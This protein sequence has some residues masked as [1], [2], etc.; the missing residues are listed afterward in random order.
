MNSQEILLALQKGKISLEEAKDELIKLKKKDDNSERDIITASSMEL[1]VGNMIMC[2]VW[3]SLEIRN[4]TVFPLK[5]ERV[6]I[7][8]GT[9]EN[10]ASLLEY[11]PGARF[12]KIKKGESIDIISEKVDKNGEI[13]H[14]IWIL[15]KKKT[16]NI[17]NDALIDAQEEGLILLFRTIKALLKLGYGVKNLC[18]SVIIDQTQSLWKDD[19]SNPAHA[20]V[21]GLMGSTANEYSTWKVRVIDLESGCKWPVDTLFG[22][23]NNV[24]CEFLAYRGGV[25]YKEKLIPVNYPAQI[26]SKYREGGVYVV[27]G[28]SGGIGEVWSEYMIRSYHAKIIW[29]GRRTIDE[30]IQKKLDRLGEIGEA[31]LYIAADAKNRNALEG[32]YKEIKEKYNEI[33]GVVHSAIVLQDRSLAM[34]EEDSFRACLSAKVD[35]S[36]RLAQVYKKEKL[37]FVLFFSSMQSFLKSAGQGNYASGSTFEDAFAEKLSH[38]W[39][40]CI[41]VINWGYWGSVGVVA[42]EDYR[43]R[44]E[45]YGAGSIEPPEAM[46]AL[47][48]LLSGPFDQI[49][50]FK[51]LKPLIIKNVDADEMIGINPE[52]PFIDTEKIKRHI[53]LREPLLEPLRKEIS[54]V[55]MKM[56]NLLCK[57]L[58]IEM[59]KMG[60]FSEKA[61]DTSSLLIDKYKAWINESIGILKRNGYLNDDKMDTVKGIDLI[62]GEEVWKEWKSLKEELGENPEVKTR[63]ILAEAAL[64]SLS[65]IIRGK[66]QAA[67]L[68]FPDLSVELVEDI[69]KYNKVRDYFNEVIADA[70]IGY[71]EQ[72]IQLD[73]S[74]L[75]RIL[76]VGARFGDTSAAVFRK[77]KDFKRHIK[78][79]CYTD[80]SGAFLK[81]GGIEFGIDHPYITFKML[82]VEEPVKQQGIDG[83]KYDIVIAANILHR[84]KDISMVLRNIKTL[85]K[86][87]GIA[88]F[89]EIAGKSVFMHLTFGLLESFGGNQEKCIQNSSNPGFNTDILKKAIEREGF[90]SL[91]F[92][93]EQGIDFGRIIMIARSD[94][95]IRYKKE[96]KATRNIKL[97]AISRI[98]SRSFNQK[99][100]SNQTANI[101]D[102]GLREKSIGFIKNLIADTLKMPSGRI[103]VLEP[104]EKYGIDSILVVRLNNS[105][106]KV[107]GENISSTLFYEYQT[108]SALVN[109]FL[110]TRKN[111]MIKLTGH[112]EKKSVK[113]EALMPSVISFRRSISVLKRYE[114]EPV[115]KEHKH[116]M[117]QDIAII[118]LSGRYACAKNVRE[119]WNNLKEG[120]NCIT[121]I[122][123]ERWD[124]KAY[125][126]EK[127]KPGKIYTKWGGFIEDFDKFDPLFFKISPREAEGMDPQERLFMEEAYSCIEDAGHTPETICDNKKVGVYVGVMNGNYPTGASYWSIANRLSYLFDFQGPSMAVDT[128]CSSSLTA[129]HLAVEG[130]HGGLCD[131]AIAG[132]VS[133]IVTP[134]HYIRLSSMT[135]LTPGERCKAF[136]DQADGFVDG[137]GVGA[138]LL[139]PLAKA[140]AD[141][142]HI[143]GVIK[144]SML[145]SG[146]KTNGYTVPNPVVQGE[147]IKEAIDKAGVNA[148]SISYIEAHGT[149]TVL[150]DPI[151]IAGLTRAFRL[152]TE[153]KQF[154]AI[155]SVKSNIGHCE[156]AAGI[157]SVT[158]VLLQLKHRKLVPS[159]HTTEL[160]PNINFCETPFVVQNKLSEW[161]SDTPRITGISSFGAGGANAHLVI[162]EYIDERL[163]DPT[164]VNA[165]YPAVIV[166]SAKDI[167]SLRGRAKSL[168]EA[169]DSDGYGNDS[170]ADIAYTLQIGREDM[171]ERL[172]F[173]SS[174][175]EEL[176]KKL[177]GFLDG[178]NGIVGIYQGQVKKNKEA[179]SLFTVDEDFQ[180]AIDNWISKGK[181]E[182]MIDLWVKGLNFNWKRLYADKKPIRISLPTYPFAK[183]RYWVEND[184]RKLF[185]KTTCVKVIHPLL[186]ENN[187]DLMEQRFSTVFSGEEFFLN[188]HRINGK[189]ILPGAVYLEMARAAVATATGNLNNGNKSILLK[190]VVWQTPVV[191]ENDPV[192]VNIGLIPGAN[193]EILFEVYSEDEVVHSQGIVEFVDKIEKVEIDLQTMFDRKWSRE[194]TAE[195]CY[196]AFI[197]AGVDYGQGHRG[198]ERIY[199]GDTEAIA[200]LSLPVSVKVGQEDY[201]LH[202][203]LM[204]AAFQA[205]FGLMD[206]NSGSAVVPYLI[207]RLEIMGDCSQSMWALV[208]LNQ[209]KDIKK[210]DID[211]CGES[212]EVCI[213][214]KGLTVRE[215]HKEDS[216]GILMLEPVWEEEKITEGIVGE[217]YTE[218]LVFLCELDDITAADV[219]PYLKAVKCIELKFKNKGNGIED[220]YQDYTI[221]MIEELRSII[222]RKPDG[223]VLIQ[224]LGS[225][226]GEAQLNRGLLGIL[227]SANLENPKIIGHLIVLEGKEGSKTIL[228]ILEENSLNNRIYI[229]KYSEGKRLVEKWKEVKK[230]INKPDIPW[231]NG[232]VYLITGGMGGLGR[233]FALDIAEKVNKATLILTGRSDLNQEMKLWIKG[234]EEKGA[235]V[236]Y[237]K[238]DIAVKADVELL[239]QGLE[240]KYGKL[241]GI[242]HSAGMIKDNY[243][244]K[245]NREEVKEVLDPKVNGLIY[246]DEASRKI[247]LDIFILFSSITGVMGN[248]GQADYAAANGFMDAFAHYR[249]EDVKLKKR[250]GMTIS[251]DWPMWK[252]GGMKIDIETEKMLYQQTG[253]SAMETENGIQALYKGLSLDLNQAMVIEGDMVKIRKKLLLND[254]LDKKKIVQHRAVSDSI[255]KN[256][257]KF[258]LEKIQTVLRKKVSGLLK[259]KIE[260]IDVDSELNEYGFDSITLTAFANELNDKFK[261]ELTPAIFFEHANLKSL[262]EYMLKEHRRA[263]DQEKAEERKDE[264]VE[265][266]AETP[267]KRES[268]HPR[269]IRG[270]QTANTEKEPIAIVGMSG[271]FPEAKDIE[272]FWKNLVEEKD[273]IREIPEK[274]WDWRKYYGDP[275]RENNKTNIKWGGFIE[276]VDE[277]DPLFFGISPREAEL[278]DPQQRLLMEYVWKAIED[279]GY[280]ADTLSGSKSGIFVGTASNGYSELIFKTKRGIEGY[281][282]TGIV[283]SVGPNRMSYFLNLHGPSE[284]VETACS[285]SLVAIHRAVSAIH[286]GSCEM[287]IAGGI[288]TIISPEIHISFYKAGML[289]EDGRCKTFSDKA[290]GYVRGEGVGMLFL[291]KLRTAEEDG[292]HIYGIIRSTVENHGGRANSLTAP[293]PKAQAELLVSAYVKA[294]IDPRTVTYV[295]A[296]GT[297]TPLGDPIEING[298]KMAFETLF[299]TVGNG[300]AANHYCG[301]GTVKSNIGHLELAAGVA[302]VIKV[303]LQL[304]YK[305]L[306]KS[307]HCE[308]INPYIE[309][310]GS[311]F[312]ILQEKKEWAPLKD[313][314]GYDIPRRAG[315]S[316]FGFGGVNAHVVIEEYI[317]KEVYKQAITSFDNPSLIVLSAKNEERLKE[318]AKN[319]LETIEKEAFGDEK[320]MEIA[321]TLQVGREEM[322]ERLGFT[323]GTIVELKEKL[324]RYLNGDILIENIYRG[325]I[326][327]NKETISVLAIDEDMARTIEAWIEKRKY[328]K[329][330][331]LWV[332]GFIFNWDKL[333]QGQKPRRISL[334]TYPFAKDRFWIE[335]RSENYQD[336]NAS[337]HYLHP[338]IHRNTSTLQ[339]IK[340][341]SKFS[342]KEPFLVDH[343][344]K[345]HNIFTNAVYLEAARAAIEYAVGELINKNSRICLKNVEFLK[346]VETDKK[347]IYINIRLFIGENN[348]IIYEIYSL[349]EGKKEIPCC[350]GTAEIIEGKEISILNLKE[351]YDKKW[352]KVLTS[353]ECYAL[354]NKL[355][356]EYGP[357]YRGIEVLQIGEIEAQAKI[358]TPASTLGSSGEYVLHPA[359]VDSAFQA[360]RCLVDTQGENLSVEPFFIDRLDIIGRFSH[361]MWALLKYKKDEEEYKFNIDLC[362]EEGKLYIK[363]KGHGNRIN[364]NLLVLNSNTAAINTQNVIT[365]ETLLEYLTG[366]LADT[367][368]MDRSDIDPDKKFIEMG[369]DSI[370]AVEWIKTINKK[371]GTQISATK[372][373]DYPSVR[374]FAIYLG[375]ELNKNTAETKDNSIFN[376]PSPI[377]LDFSSD[378]QSFQNISLNKP[379]EIS[380]SSFQDKTNISKS[381]RAQSKPA[382]SLS[383]NVN[384]FFYNKDR[385]N[386]LKSR[387]VGMSRIAIG[388]RQE[389]RRH[390][391]GGERE[392]I[393][394][395]GMSGRYP[396]AEDI[397]QYW[398]NLEG[399]KNSIREIPGKR[400]EMKKYYHPDP[401][402][403]M[404]GKIYCKWLGMLEEIEYFDPLFFNISPVEAE[405]MDP[406]HRIFI[407]E[408]YKAFEDAGYSPRMLSDQKCGVY[409]GIMSNEY[410]MM[411]YQNQ[412]V[413][414]NATGNSYSIGAAR[415]P[416]FLNLKGPAIPIDTACSSSL[417][418]GYLGM[419]ALADHEIDMALIGGVTL[420]LTPQTYIGMCAAGML[421]PEGQCKTFDNGANG[422]VPGEGVG[423]IVLKRLTDA[424][425]DRDHIYGVII[426]GGINQDGKTNG[427]T[428]PSVNSQI[429]LEREI[430]N[431]YHIEPESIGYVEMHGTGTKLGDPIELEALSTV[432]RERTNRK[433]YCAIGSV[434]S[435][436]GHTSAASGIASIQKV[437]LCM[438]MKSLYRR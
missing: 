378:D 381:E 350:F 69:Y 50:F 135:M 367:L 176:K 224:I 432:Y 194:I 185:H 360:M 56:E 165:E 325:H 424:E 12:L 136:G 55:Q 422:F 389:E 80:A 270:G 418:A 340:F 295:E 427:I 327:Q 97:E 130:L 107:F 27:I 116:C 261:L 127:G 267:E 307:L 124:W 385:S 66:A 101:K 238:A 271:A 218:R 314:R 155:G 112:S 386:I 375:N 137:E 394:V 138:I 298:L 344:V 305:T 311:P 301:L 308:N 26:K 38:I 62:D 364:M 34:M 290:N 212:G 287:A 269:F 434:K 265:I 430:Y 208:K 355:D 175:I 398:E 72:R 373:Y 260:D 147:L 245:K 382:I 396:G 352:I 244:F 19:V 164:V 304:K 156:S 44:M 230:E 140:V 321:Y 108:I 9:D 401:R 106:R 383:E 247:K 264:T 59:K 131:C 240:E 315:V 47:E 341:S 293:N 235:R 88:L 259:V 162:E 263:F 190:N 384:L 13:N 158:K 294:G 377:S 6:V 74:A 65:L 17:E 300:N 77:I 83:G 226:K 421:S 320:L 41:K 146:G 85:L 280:S 160:N 24:Q 279:A 419:Q 209:N 120:R 89:N 57:L 103:G 409:L 395:I 48:K 420:Y 213:R 173:T 39:D 429:E 416:Y 21:D 102:E 53:T 366:S 317:G 5:T 4:S 248:A 426:G 277:F 195:E 143:Y 363:I 184:S 110:K 292:D 70:L 400:W 228:K 436:I 205:I 82:N 402:Q 16:D 415:I 32:A 319:L 268:I 365:D 43:E 339:E 95:V 134:D 54:E 324:N 318:I 336:M 234:L 49:V 431:K 337:V 46:D 404:E 18:W 14:I 199:A 233:L 281:S 105:L 215:M 172:G 52:G 408:G 167:T 73:P 157:A 374:E 257:D 122:P 166:L 68:V 272:E 361:T 332:N 180:K 153:D 90:L 149:G 202:P 30:G 229:T 121:E 193:R 223:K 169:I 119:F 20:G 11:N 214:V 93:V 316:S 354:L 111:E 118:G 1:P 423:A 266:G 25:W 182:K 312:Y 262:S 231:K 380:L 196:E 210:Y 35:I 329:L 330:I 306:V 219:E 282:S 357:T 141:G 276:G 411:L 129:I 154:C 284:P 372:V 250:Y 191:V 78:E 45:R 359:I 7:I 256:N 15:P 417:V 242:I 2:P 246:L 243:L 283:P 133:L 297:G 274:R 217:E 299:K 60:F 288:N 221:R 58:W 186:Q 412:R 8:G 189:K 334:P 99:L 100:F 225:G 126:D 29:I 309:L 310:E 71:I 347:Y 206:W 236:E 64:Q 81:H 84:V 345:G 114:T 42:S 413:V 302:G 117:E 303:L 399:G 86:K 258:L 170:L 414:T 227:K 207:D 91:I 333:Y 331:E 369:M 33:N 92:P 410:G 75:F 289:C 142:D 342:G 368:Y 286:D 139:K 435:N 273:C 76:E 168:L 397:E 37:D 425:R 222:E 406:Q 23:S 326:K 362:D 10:R 343:K 144:G 198:I 390:S 31:P 63:I 351:Y 239:F 163:R 171:E 232:G 159:L 376:I 187:S 255:I 437:L 192:K 204:D 348:E 358:S 313:I 150:G 285:S 407:Q 249:N 3:D 177:I 98:K 132:G 51:T 36:V 123:K 403:Y 188:D 152:F 125:F 201:L 161:E 128:A 197:K 278:M 220:R 151:E 22:V 323:A 322:E 94:G 388:Q 67:D 96:T 211:V 252:D 438:N 178:E 387:R 393:A 291:K 371:Y 216:I 145:N 183:D 104:L 148:R 349:G 28:G 61:V 328:G 370:I 405:G 391:K 356:I 338:L 115:K 251:V 113:E 241:N 87:N 392:G 181:Y 253:I 254:Y 379:E 200:K 109:Y 174:S 296:H 353:E 433:K 275:N 346:P 237:C 40:C 335:E 203:S 428:A 179:L 79:Y